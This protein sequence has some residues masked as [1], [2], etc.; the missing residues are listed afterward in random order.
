MDYDKATNFLSLMIIKEDKN[1]FYF[2]LYNQDDTIDNIN[3]NFIESNLPNRL[4]S[5]F[6]K[7]FEFLNV[8]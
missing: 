7:Y 2:D 3:D 8:L 1:K 6:E 4:I 5:F